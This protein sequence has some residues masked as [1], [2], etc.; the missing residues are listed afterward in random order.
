MKMCI[1][2]SW[3]A[4][5]IAALPAF[6]AVL[7]CAAT[8]RVALPRDRSDGFVSLAEAVRTPYNAS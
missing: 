6:A 1:M 7:F 3:I 5:S 2:L 8:G 4:V